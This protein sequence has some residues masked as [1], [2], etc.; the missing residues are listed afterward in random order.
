[1]VEASTHRIRKEP[2]LESFFS[3]S[4]SKVASGCFTRFFRGWN[5]GS[6]GV[7]KTFAKFL[8]SETFVVR[9]VFVT[10]SETKGCAMG[11]ITT[12]TLLSAWFITHQGVYV[13]SHAN[14]VSIV[15][16]RMVYVA[17]HPFFVYQ[18]ARQ[19]TN[20]L[21]MQFLILPL[22]SFLLQNIA[23]LYR[24]TSRSQDDN[25]FGIT[26]LEPQVAWHWQKE[27]LT[28]LGLVPQ[29]RRSKR[30]CRAALSN[31]YIVNRQVHNPS[32]YQTKLRPA[33]VCQADRKSRCR[34]Y[35][36]TVSYLFQIFSVR[37]SSQ[38]NTPYS[39]CRFGMNVVLILQMFWASWAWLWFAIH[40]F[41]TYRVWCFCSYRSSAELLAGSYDEHRKCV[42]SL[43]SATTSWFSTNKRSLIPSVTLWLPG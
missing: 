18:I 8:S 40:S 35:C 34:R 29:K 24:T 1:M 39:S 9:Y 25:L 41:G 7:S 36:K 33:L 23:I 28:K 15:F 11:Y 19:N 13:L 20:R 14:T 26:D 32:G 16:N 27:S 12:A 37:L 42:L 22:S 21:D 10:K 38:C 30:Y 31:C 4:C 6:C 17:E 3:I 2:L 5:V 43:K